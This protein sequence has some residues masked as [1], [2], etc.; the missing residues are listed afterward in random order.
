VSPNTFIPF[1][2]TEWLFELEVCPM[3][4]V[5][6]DRIPKIKNVVNFISV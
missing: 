2:K 5:K 1:K 4:E 3:Q 6:M